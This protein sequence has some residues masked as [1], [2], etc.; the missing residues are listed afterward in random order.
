MAKVIWKFDIGD[1]TNEDNIISL[2]KDTQIL[3]IQLQY[4]V[5]CLWAVVDPTAETEKRHFI[6][7]MTGQDI[8]N[9]SKET[10]K[11]ITTLQIDGGIFDEVLV[12]HI[13]EIAS[14]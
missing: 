2:P 14:E 3:D 13:F 12:V 9:Y 1:F 6:L 5:V 10:H 4:E 7:A 8:E 11:Y